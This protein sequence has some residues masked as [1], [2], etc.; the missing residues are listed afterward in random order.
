MRST[1][2]KTQETV[3]TDLHFL[4]LTIHVSSATAAAVTQFPI[5]VS[6][7]C[8]QTSQMLLS[9]NI[10]ATYF[11]CGHCNALILPTIAINYNVMSPSAV[12]LP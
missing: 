10:H 4:L 9:L 3:R 6:Y 7:A 1:F 2:Q 5:N 8:L 12:H 11:D